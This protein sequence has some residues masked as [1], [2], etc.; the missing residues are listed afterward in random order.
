MHS[1]DTYK[2]IKIIKNAGLTEEQAEA[3]VNTVA[4]SREYDFSKL[5]SKEQID[6]HIQHL[7]NKFD[8]KF[9]LA[10]QR[11]ESIEK[12]MATKEDLHKLEATLLKWMI[13]LL[14]TIIGMFCTVIFKLFVA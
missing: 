11:F 2:F 9:E 1:F 14:I 3:I 8:S 10:D 4:E 5:A 6:M 13:P 12:N 7:E